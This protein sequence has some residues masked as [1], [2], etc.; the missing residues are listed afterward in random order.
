MSDNGALI[1]I[2]IAVLSDIP[3]VFGIPTNTLNQMLAEYM[4]RK[5][6]EARDILL[7]EVSKANLNEW[8]AA[9]EDETISAIFRYGIA[10]RD[11]TARRN[12]KLMA[13]AMCGLAERNN[14]RTDEFAKYAGILSVL[15]RDQIIFLGTFMTHFREERKSESDT[16][17]ITGSALKQTQD[18]L[19]PILFET[20]E[21]MNIAMIQ[22][23]SMGLLGMVSA[24]GGLIHPPTVLLEEI[25]DLLDIKRVIDDE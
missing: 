9:S 10:A 6:I 24:F 18:D 14:L 17:K 7:E 8:D 16:T 19:I 13:Q 15:T 20:K 1:K 2:G 3:A 4:R 22:C 21:R 5:G 23:A 12:L 11:G 25:V